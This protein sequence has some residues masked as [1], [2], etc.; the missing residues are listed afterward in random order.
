MTA[1]GEPNQPR[2]GDVPA[3]VKI[4][5]VPICYKNVMFLNEFPEGAHCAFGRVSIK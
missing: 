4:F 1:F 2:M 3:T 5:N